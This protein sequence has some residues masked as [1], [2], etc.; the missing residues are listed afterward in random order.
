MTDKLE[1]ETFD[2]D[3]DKFTENKWAA[4]RRGII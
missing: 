1:L 2:K 4:E 3:S